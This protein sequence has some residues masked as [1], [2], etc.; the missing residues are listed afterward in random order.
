MV[1]KRKKKQQNE[2][3]L[4]QLSESDTYFMIGQNNHEAQTEDRS[5]AV[6]GDIPLY[7]AKA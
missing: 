5:N 2:K 1:S 7:N 6:D 3:L 4:S